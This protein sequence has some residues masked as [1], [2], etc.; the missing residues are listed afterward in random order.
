MSSPRVL[1]FLLVLISGFGAGL[2]GSVAPAWSWG[3]TGHR[4][5]G[6]IAQRHL[7]ESAAAGVGDLVGPAGL[8]RVADWPDDIRSDA[9]LGKDK[10]TWHYVTIPDGETYETVEKEPKGDIVER[11]RHFEAVLRD[12]ATERE[13][14][15]DALAWLVHLVGDVHQPLHVGREG[16]AGGNAVL[17]LWFGEPSN[18]HRVWD[19]EM[20]DRTHL[21]FSEIVGFIDHP[22]PE[23]VETWQASD[24]L[25]WVV[26]SMALREQVY[27]LGDRKLGYGYRYKNRPVVERRLLQAGVR[28]AGLLNAIFAPPRD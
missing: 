5:V 6:A 19:S 24:L 12:P 8:A 7:S 18:L 25:D 2:L 14:R 28:L 9:V 11:I 15:W 20:I 26:E 1:G 21:S 10:E 17:V 13:A 3:A 23:E 16:D 27:D 22:T 4:V